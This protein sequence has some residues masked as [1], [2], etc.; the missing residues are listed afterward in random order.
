MGHE[1]VGE[2]TIRYY[3]PITPSLLAHYS[4]IAVKRL[5]SYS[6]P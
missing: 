2:L 5:G 6:Q 1:G 3:S 4:L